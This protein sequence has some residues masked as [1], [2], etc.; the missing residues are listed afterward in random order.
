MRNILTMLHKQVNDPRR[1]KS[2]P[3][4]APVT[5]HQRAHQ[6]KGIVTKMAI[7]T[8]RVTERRIVAHDTSR[9]TPATR[10]TPSWC[11]RVVRLTATVQA[12]DDERVW[13]VDGVG[14]S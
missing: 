6:V 11:G 5:K 2:S 3:V 14:R 4:T 8:D 10:A 7:S 1:A 13:A 12:A 9:P